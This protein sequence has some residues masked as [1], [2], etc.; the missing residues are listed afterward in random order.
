MAAVVKIVDEFFGSGATQRVVATQLT[1]ASERIT[2][3]ELIRRRIADEVDLLNKRA[4]DTSSTHMRT[5][6]FIVDVEAHAEA[7]LNEPFRLF[8]KPRVLDT[9]TELQTALQGF[10]DGKFILLFD[11]RQITELDDDITLTKHSE[12]VFL[13]LTPLRGG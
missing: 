6:S 11:D 1:L 9:E 4:S 7:R 2:A 8:R 13:Y 3:R 5:R 10:S 12:A